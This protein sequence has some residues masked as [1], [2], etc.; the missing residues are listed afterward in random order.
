MNANHPDPI[1]SRGDHGN[2]RGKSRR[3]EAIAAVVSLA[4]IALL[5]AVDVVHG[6]PADARPV[7]ATFAVAAPAEVT[8]PTASETW[9]ADESA[10]GTRPDGIH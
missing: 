6:A 2:G 3:V 8:T 1:A 5:A 4:V 10:Q 9:A 7:P